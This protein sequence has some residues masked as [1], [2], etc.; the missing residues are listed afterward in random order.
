MK[1]WCHSHA[2]RT[3]VEVTGINYH[4]HIAIIE[5]RIS[6]KGVCIKVGPV[7][8]T[9]RKPSRLVHQE[10]SQIVCFQN[11]VKFI[12][13]IFNKLE[14]PQLI[15]LM[16]S[17]K[18]SAKKIIKLHIGANSSTERIQNPMVFVYPGVS[19]AGIYLGGGVG[20]P[21]KEVITHPDI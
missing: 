1:S 4:V 3:F 10:H 7:S 6:S 8:F 9:S 19:S 13:H 11:R 5:S 20:G 16:Q 12:H 21:I 15:M 2:S 14:C 17:K 18:L